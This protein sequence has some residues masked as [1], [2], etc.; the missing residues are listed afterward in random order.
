MNS[1]YDFVKN[2]GETDRT[3]YDRIFRTLEEN[4]YVPMGRT[5]GEHLLDGSMGFGIMF[6][7]VK[8]VESGMERSDLIP[9]CVTISAP[10]DIATS[11]KMYERKRIDTQSESED[12]STDSRPEL[13]IKIPARQFD[14]D[15][16]CAP[17]AADRAR[18]YSSDVSTPIT[19]PASE[20]CHQIEGASMAEILAERGIVLDSTDTV[21]NATA[22]TSDVKPE[23]TGAINRLTF[24][25]VTTCLLCGVNYIGTDCEIHYF[26]LGNKYGWMMCDNCIRNGWAKEEIVTYLNKSKKIPLH[27]LFQYRNKFNFDG[28]IVLKFWRR[29]RQ[30]VYATSMQYNCGMNTTGPIFSTNPG[31]EDDNA[32]DIA[33]SDYMLTADPEEARQIEVTEDLINNTIIP[34]RAKDLASRGASL[35]N[36]FY[37]NHGLYDALASTHSLLGMCPIKIALDDLSPEIQEMVKQHLTDAESSDGKF[38]R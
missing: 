11:V 6:V 17:T 5:Y 15:V 3:F 4:G 13:S 27:F 20:C 10:P 38:H 35:R 26:D 7:P 29:S 30:G 9:H 19:A 32:I 1:Y 36:L 2:P 12:E 14:N 28:N 34:N 25:N 31:E 33:F 8:L 16:P 24:L 23:I 37:Y 18:D 21:G 22:S